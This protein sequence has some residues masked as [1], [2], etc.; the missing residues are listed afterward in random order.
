MCQLGYFV[1]SELIYDENKLIFTKYYATWLLLFSTKWNSVLIKIF[2]NFAAEE[3]V[4]SYKNSIPLIYFS[5]KWGFLNFQSFPSYRI[6][7]T[8]QKNK[9][10]TSAFF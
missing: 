2:S 8:A 9:P 4:P 5:L 10:D 7:S 3:L 6:G 1:E